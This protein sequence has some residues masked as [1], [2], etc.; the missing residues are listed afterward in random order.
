MN[1]QTIMVLILFAAAIF[2]VGRLLYNNIFAKKTGC[3]SNCKCSVDFS[4]I[5]TAGA[6]HNN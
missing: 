4:K 2:Y 1:V 3:G 6:K 5:E